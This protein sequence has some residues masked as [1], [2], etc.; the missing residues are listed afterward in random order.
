VA[1]VF[2]FGVS[3]SAD[4]IRLNGHELN[5]SYGVGTIE[6]ESGWPLQTL[7][8]YPGLRYVATLSQGGV[9]VTQTG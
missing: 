8:I 9:K 4:P 1:V 3:P 7:T 6:M 5:C 2:T